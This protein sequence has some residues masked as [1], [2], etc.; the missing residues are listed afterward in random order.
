MDRIQRLVLSRLPSLSGNFPLTSTLT[1][2]LFGLLH[3]SNNSNYSIYAI[4]S[5]TRLPQVS[6]GSK[7]G[8]DQLLHHLRFS[9]EYLRRSGILDI[10]GRPLNLHNVASHL[11]YTEP[12]NL[13]LIALIRGGVLHRI[14]KKNMIDAKDELMSLFCHLFGRRHLPLAYT[15]KVVMAGLLKAYPSRIVLGPLN[16][17]AQEVLRAHNVDVLSVFSAYSRLFSTQHR[18]KLGDD[19]VLPL[20]KGIIKPEPTRDEHPS[21]L[22]EYLQRHRVN[23]SS[24]SL[25]VANSGLSDQCESVEELVWTC[26]EGLHLNARAIPSFGGILASTGGRTDVPRLNAYI[27]DFYKHG[28]IATLSRANGIRKGD[29]WYILNDFLLSLLSVRNALQELLRTAESSE[30]D[31]TED[32]TGGAGEA[33]DLE[34]TSFP[35]PAGVSDDDWRVYEVLDRLVVEFNDKFK[36]MWA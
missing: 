8:R 20:S 17:D 31:E 1:A 16:S 6:F 10:N 2:R 9:I 32:G 27:L 18:D 21:R 35:R 12:S 3:G 34:L 19:N 7:T 23:V 36:K 14:C 29:I 4:R 25:F 11:Y 28:Q 5:I 22:Q 24:R 26:R 30:E 15:S 13:A 33:E